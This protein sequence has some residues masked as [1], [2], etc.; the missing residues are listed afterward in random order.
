MGDLCSQ[1]LHLPLGVSPTPAPAML[2]T[3]SFP[4]EIWRLLTN[5]NDVEHVTQGQGSPI[6]R[7]YPSVVRS[8]FRHFAN[9]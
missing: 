1:V 9:C 5:T 3:N 2:P 6:T 4:S 7:Q 8:M